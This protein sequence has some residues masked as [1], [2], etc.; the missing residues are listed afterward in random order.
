[1]VGDRAKLEE[2]NNALKKLHFQL[3]GLIL[4]R[5]KTEVLSELPDKVIQDVTVELSKKQKEIYRTFCGSDVIDSLRTAHANRKSTNRASGTNSLVNLRKLQSV[6]NDASLL[7][8]GDV[9]LADMT[10]SS[11]LQALQDIIHNASLGY[12]PAIYQTQ[13]GKSQAAGV[14]ET[15]I[16]NSQRRS[17]KAVD[18]KTVDA[19]LATDDLIHSHTA[20][21][22]SQLSLVATSGKQEE[23]ENG[24]NLTQKLLVFSRFPKMLKKVEEAL[25]KPH[26]PSL[27]YSK[28]DGSTPTENRQSI[29]QEFNADPN[30]KVLLLSTGVGNL[31]LNLASAN[32]VV[33]IDHSW[34][35]FN[36]L[37]AMDRAH[38]L[39]QRQTVFV[40]RLISKGTIE[41]EIMNVQEFKKLISSSVIGSDEESPSTVSA[42]AIDAGSC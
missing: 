31:G 2:A 19:S 28:I 8:D 17:Q 6:C 42:E 13:D 36:D 41:E 35:P 10:T 21:E 1:M 9:H 24:E 3:K 4:R 12:E 40:Y 11:K 26:F 20:H 32:I 15:A 27:K 38:R 34:N 22:N 18:W 37:Q 33:F 29:A 16:G 5:T 39:G 23:S 25:L 7:D 30:I 14:P